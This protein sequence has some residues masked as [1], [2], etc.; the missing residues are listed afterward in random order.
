M[1][2]LDPK[3]TGWKQKLLHEMKEYWLSVFYMAVVITVFVNYRRLILAHYQ[4]SYGEWGIG[5]IKA[6]VLAKVV[7]VAEGLNLGRRFDHKPL[8]IPTLYKT[9]LF[10]VCVALFDA[11]ESMVSSLFHGKVF[12]VAINDIVNG[13]N[14]EWLAGVLV[15]FFAFIPFFAV[16]ELRKILGEGTIFKYFFQKQT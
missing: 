14:Y 11:V 6:L 4:I 2:T 1:S 8:V 12:G 3:R 15:V 5:V 10:T 9:L 16:K 7:L 13:Y